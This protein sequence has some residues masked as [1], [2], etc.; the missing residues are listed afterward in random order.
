MRGI[1]RIFGDGDLTSAPL[2]FTPA[3]AMIFGHSH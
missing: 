3:Y 1:T 2:I